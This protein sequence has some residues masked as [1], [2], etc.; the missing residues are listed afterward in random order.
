MTLQH[1]QLR[2]MDMDADRCGKW[3]RLGLVK[4]QGLFFWKYIDFI[5]FSHIYRSLK[6]PF[7]HRSQIR[8]IETRNKLKSWVLW[9][10]GQ[11]NSLI[12]WIGGKIHSKSWAFFAELQNHLGWAFA[13]NWAGWSLGHSCVKK[14]R[15]ETEEP[16]LTLSFCHYH[17]S[18]R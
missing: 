7:K 12:F 17:G 5:H 15:F 10:L 16:I 9:F 3:V 1:H 14:Q 11:N 6:Q 18:L 8:F 4:A 2:S 13:S